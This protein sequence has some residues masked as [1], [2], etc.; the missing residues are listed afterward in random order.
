MNEKV[1]SAALEE[2]MEDKWISNYCTKE[3]AF[4]SSTLV[5]RKGS[6]RALQPAAKKRQHKEDGDTASK[7]LK[8]G[9]GKTQPNADLAGK[10]KGKKGSR[11]LKETSSKPLRRSFWQ[12]DR[13]QDNLAMAYGEH[14]RTTR[15]SEKNPP[16]RRIRK[17]KWLL[18]DSGTLEE[19]NVLP[20]IK[21]HGLKHQKHHRSSFVK[22]AESGQIKNNVKYKPSVNSN[23]KAK[24]NNK[25]QRGF[26]LECVKPDTAPQ[27]ILELSLP[28][29]ELMGTFTEDT[30][31]RQRGF[32]QV[33]LYKPTVKL[34]A[35]SQPVKTVHRKEVVLRARDET[36][37]VLQL[38]CYARQQKGKGKGLNT[39]GSVSTITRSSVQGSPPKEPPRELCEKPAPEMKT[40]IASQTPVAADVAESRDLEKALQ[41]QTVKAVS[42]KTS[43]ARERSENFAA[44]MRTTTASQTLVAAEV[45]ETPML[46]KVSQAQTR[47]LVGELCEESAVEMKVTIASQTPTV[48]KV[49][50]SPDLDKVSKVPAVEDISKITASPKV[51][52][53]TTADDNQVEVT[54]KIPHLSNTANMSN[55]AP[56]ESMPSQSVDVALRDGDQQLKSFSCNSIAKTDVTEGSSKDSR[57]HGPSEN[58]RSPGRSVVTLTRASEIQAASTAIDHDSINDI[59]ALTLVT[60]MVTELAPEGLAQE[61]ENDKQQAP[62]NSPSKDSAA[63]SKPKVPHRISAISSCSVPEEEASTV[64]DVQGKKGKARTRDIA[65]KTPENSEP[66][67][68]LPESEESKLEY[69]CTFCNKVF[70][71]SRVV[72]HAM[73]HYRQ[74]KCM[75]CGTVFKDD[76]LAM[77]HLSDHIEK[78]KKSK[79]SV[80]KKGQE[81]QITETKDIS[82]PKTSAKAKTTDVSSGRRSSGRLKKSPVCPKSGSLPDSSPPKCRKL[83]SN[84]KPV[85][86]QFLQEKKQ[87]TLKHLNGETHVHKVNGH[88]GKKQELDRTKK[89]LEAKEPLK[90]QK[91]LHEKKSIGYE[92][93]GLPENHDMEVD[94]STSSATVEKDFGCSRESEMKE[95]ESLQVSKKGTKQNGKVVEEK[96]VEP[97]EKVCCPVDGCAWFTDLSKNRVA[98]LYHALEDHHGEVKPLELAFRVGNSRCS[99]CMRVLWSFEHFLHHVERHRLSP[100]HP[101]LHQG[102]TARFKTGMEM[103]RHAR[104]HSP[105]QAV[106]CLPGCSQLFICLWALNL[107]EREHYASKNAKPDK[108][109]D[110]QTGDRQNNTQTGKKQDLKSIDATATPAVNKTESVK[111]APKLRR[112]P[113]RNTSS[114]KHNASPLSTVRTSLLK[115]DLK[116]RNET[117]DLNI[118]KNLSN[119]DAS[120][121][122][123]VS[124]LRLR[125]RLRKVTNK[126]LT[127]PKTHK[128]ISSSLLKHNSKLRHKFKRM[129]VKL[130]TKGPKRRGR[131]PKSKK[132]VHDENNTAAQN[133]E[134]VKTALQKDQRSPAQLVSNS[135]AAE[136]S[137][138]SNKLKEEKR[139]HAATETS[140]DESKLKKSVDKQP[141]E[142][143][144]KQQ[145]VSH[146]TPTAVVTANT[147]NKSIT[148]TSDDKMKKLHKVKKHSTGQSASS[149]SGKSKKHKAT[150][151]KTNI[152]KV[153]KKGPLKEPVSALKKPVK[154]K[155]VV[156]TKAAEAV[157]KTSDEVGKAQA[158]NTDS[159]QNNPE[160]PVPAVTADSLS[161]K[162]APPTSSG[163]TTQKLTTEDKS[164]KSHIAKKEGK[165]DRYTQGTCSG[166]ASKRYKDINKEGDKRTV[167]E[168]RPC[169]DSGNTSVAKKM[170]AKS[171]VQQQVEAKATL[172]NTV[173]EGGKGKVEASDQTLHS[174]GPS[175]AAVTNSLNRK[176]SQSA[177]TADPTQ[178]ITE[179]KSKI[180]RVMK[181][182]DP[183]KANQKRK[184]NH[185]QSDTKIVKKTCPDQSLT[186]GKAAVEET[187]AS[188]ESKTFA[189]T[190]QST[191]S[192]PGY[193]L[194]MNGQAINEDSKSTVSTDILAKYS[195]RPYMRLPPTAYLDEK[196]ITMPKRRKEISFFPWSQ[197]GSTPEQASVTTAVQRQRCANCFA[198]FNSA[199]ELQS[200][201]QL[202]KCST[203]FGFDSDDEGESESFI[204]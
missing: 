2:I 80:G 102:C 185:R 171:E 81:N 93:L 178:K 159:T 103:R 71:G 67:E 8:V 137:N 143:H 144:V 146:N 66:I 85:D 50:Q 64:S 108:N 65:P 165:K 123:T 21:R 134:T 79:E 46:D 136:A 15:L 63:G 73:F 27:V 51:S 127:A 148:T 166:E 54:D 40:R 204:I 72:A 62:E 60:E 110:M 91:N 150:N 16:K 25:Q 129:Q 86:G 100:R 131:P 70:K 117:K 1:V 126:T 87:N 140:I 52:H 48:A 101:C 57:G 105:L 189:G 121:Q 3:P 97:Q 177:A 30:C 176:T 35:T 153:R 170:K 162:T 7:R 183:N 187:F 55:I 39:Q 128:A 193:S 78:L 141:K 12:L 44:K 202:Q 19:N 53:T 61:L 11:T 147:L 42:R 92:N 82:T 10:K 14:R 109:T 114:R 113:T 133:N 76:L 190:L 31:N 6:K 132:A 116:E 158:E 194:V 84:D 179:K 145:G 18:E 119:K 169:K 104:K 9:P 34:P 24:E 23:L 99:I 17:P 106:C 83:R 43:S 96:N 124:N 112:P 152:K 156:E 164:K 49:T 172:V 77:M 161:E 181:I 59:S 149:D 142:N 125:Q 155:S 28:D 139:K 22:R 89:N 111:V 197:K 38:H 69:C 36:M 160:N 74:D 157:V 184:N 196:Y 167:K 188:E 182:S 201:L 180:T 115:Q 130:N 174:T 13:I 122:P 135:K 45:T 203:L 41:A 20:K 186:D 47:A 90:Q 26:S 138:L 68:K 151:S 94:S 56:S 191:I 192:S 58:D 118:L 120:A 88:I 75:F 198:T 32:P 107:H 195:K 95:T 37:F 163:E 200:H 173:D 5:C 98:L 33:L 175:M 29:N 168:K 154:S 4:R 199:E